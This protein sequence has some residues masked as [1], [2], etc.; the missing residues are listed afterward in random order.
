M[1]ASRI[2]EVFGTPKVFLPVIHPIT[3][4]IA[5]Q[6]IRVAVEAGADGIFLIDQGMSSSE[7]LAFIPEVHSRYPDLWVGVN[8]LDTPAPETIGRVLGLP[9]GGIWSDNAGVDERLDDQEEASLF[10]SSRLKNKWD[11]LYFGGV[12]FKYQRPVHSSMQASAAEKSKPFVDIITTS[13]SGTGVATDLE[14]VKTLRSGAGTHPLGLASG[15]TPGNVD[16]YLPYVDVFLVASGIETARYSGVLVPSKTKELSDR[17][18]SYA[19]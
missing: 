15:I 19:I 5:L 17:I 14:K 6:S 2:T 12:A 9:A 11:G 3:K 16:E 4:S 13:G 8:L 18:H 7:L 10:L 1:H